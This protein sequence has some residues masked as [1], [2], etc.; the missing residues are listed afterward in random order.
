[1]DFHALS[2]RELQAL[3]KRNAVRANMSNAAMADALQALPS[4]SIFQS[5]IPFG[6]SLRNLFLLRV[7]EALWSERWMSI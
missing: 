1:M 3:C 2:R 7:C 5:P 6:E 4:V